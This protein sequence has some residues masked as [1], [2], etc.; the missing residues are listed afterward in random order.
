MMQN[1]S[2]KSRTDWTMIICLAGVHSFLGRN[3][4]HMGSIMY[5]YKFGHLYVSV[6]G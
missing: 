5:R 3:G 1:E 4:P 6:S 2:A